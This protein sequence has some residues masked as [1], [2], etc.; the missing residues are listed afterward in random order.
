LKKN[1][2][3]YR[4]HTTPQPQEEEYLAVTGFGYLFSHYQ[5]TRGSEGIKENYTNV[6]LQEYIKWG[7]DLRTL[8]NNVQKFSVRTLNNKQF[9][10]VERW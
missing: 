9:K 2:F 4:L 1:N 5:T 7:R 6:P 8:H 3:L 10:K